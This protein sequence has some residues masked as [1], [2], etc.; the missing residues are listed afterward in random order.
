MASFSHERPRQAKLRPQLRDPWNRARRSTIDPLPRSGPPSMMTRVG[1]PAVCESTT[2]IRCMAR[3]IRSRK[4]RRNPRP[5]P[6]RPRSA[7]GAAVSESSGGDQRQSLGI[8]SRPRSRKRESLPDHCVCPAS[9]SILRERNRP[10]DPG[11]SP[12]PNRLL[13]G[14]A[15][16]VSSGNHGFSP[17]ASP[18]IHHLNRF[19]RG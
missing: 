6:C 2:R 18:D 12:C 11:Y 5:L 7:P 4:W 10:W 17:E 1:S 14:Y 3:S 9:P 16:N 13:S 8:L 19:V 15:D